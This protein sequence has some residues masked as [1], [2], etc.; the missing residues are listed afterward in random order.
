M[1][2]E[3]QHQA[4]QS[5]IE[6]LRRFAA[7]DGFSVNKASERDFWSFLTSMPFLRRAGVILMENGNLR[8]VWRSD[9][10]SRLALQFLG[11]RS[12]E[13]VIFKRRRGA[14]EVSRAAGFDTLDGLKRQI[15]AFDLT[16][17][18]YA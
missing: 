11:N 1:L 6:E 4:Y 17:L 14:K 12:V 15:Y 9:D 13:Y 18:V 3:E 2:A 5:R 16:T 8:A 10:K 7:L